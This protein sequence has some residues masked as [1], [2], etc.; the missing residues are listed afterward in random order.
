M[1]DYGILATNLEGTFDQLKSEMAQIDPKMLEYLDSFCAR[2]F[3]VSL[4]MLSGDYT[5]AQYAAFHSTA[6]EPFINELEQAFSAVLYTQREQD[7]GHMV[8]FYDSLVE[9][10]STEHKIKLF[11]AGTNTGLIT[12]NE[13]RAMF[14]W[15]PVEGGDVR[16]MSLAYIDA[17]NAA[18]YQVG[19]DGIKTTKLDELDESIEE[20][21]EGEENGGNE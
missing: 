6:I 4:A 13:G 19:T 5:Y 12:V 3:G 15:E 7:L 8:K 2:R 20:N 21:E 17:K 18:K 10:Y 14:G 11:S 16:I 1:S 9:H